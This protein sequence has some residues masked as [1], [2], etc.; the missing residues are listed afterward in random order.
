[1]EIGLWIVNN[2]FSLENFRRLP[3]FSSYNIREDGSVVFDT[4]VKPKNEI[5][6]YLTKFSGITPAL[7]EPVTTTV[8]DVQ[9]VIR[10]VLPPDAILCGHSLEFD[11]RAMRMAHPYTAEQNGKIY[12]RVK[13]NKPTTFSSLL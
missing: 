1:M 7:M 4:L 11:L 5:T 13:H 9:E 3:H 10:A 12:N 6:D 2:R 8:E